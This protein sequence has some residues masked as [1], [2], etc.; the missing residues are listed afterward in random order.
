LIPNP[1]LLLTDITIRQPSG[2][3]DQLLMRKNKVLQQDANMSMVPM[4]IP[5]R[6]PNHINKNK[7]IIVILT[8]TLLK[9]SN[10]Q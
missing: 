4:A 7:R 10:T 5:H 3:S 6:L 8:T 2:H 9:D 1:Y